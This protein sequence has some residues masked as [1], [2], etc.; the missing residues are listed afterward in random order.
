MPNKKSFI[1]RIEEGIL[2]LLKNDYMC[3]QDKVDD[4]LAVQSRKPQKVPEGIFKTITINQTQVFA[5]GDENADKT[6]LFIHGGAYVNEINYQHLFY[7]RKLARK[8]NAR[9]LAPVYPLAPNHTADETFDI[10]TDLY[11]P[12]V[13][14]DNLTLM[15]DSAGGGFVLSFAQYLKTIDLPQPDHIIVFSPWVDVS[16]SGFPYDDESDPM[17]GEVGLR[18]IGKSWAG[19]IDVRDY[20]VSP[21]YGDNSGLADVLIFAGTNEIFYKDIKKYVSKLKDEDVNVRF[22]EA[23]GLFHVYPMFPMPE[24]RKAF[25]EIEKEIIN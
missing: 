2:R 3:S 8:L 1:A 23:E 6:I 22:I 7:C 25:K 19:E 10:V 14:K 5:F 15:G 16:M 13:D 17:L 20:R 21:L 4:F 12:L 9:V 18:R 24:A 11:K